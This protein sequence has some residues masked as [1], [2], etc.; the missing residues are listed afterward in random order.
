MSTFQP[1]LPMTFSEL[2][3]LLEMD[4]IVEWPTHRLRVLGEFQAKKL[5]CGTRRFS[6]RNHIQDSV[7]GQYE[8]RTESNERL[9]LPLDFS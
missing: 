3:T 4:D 9:S 8:P 5:D 6:L 7:I 2:K 1:Y